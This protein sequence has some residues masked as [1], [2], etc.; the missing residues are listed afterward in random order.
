MKKSWALW[1]VWNSVWSYVLFWSLN[2][3]KV[4]LEK[5]SAFTHWVALYFPEFLICFSTLCS[6]AA[7]PPP[8]PPPCTAAQK[9]AG[10]SV[11]EVLMMAEVLVVTA[12]KNKSCML[13]WGCQRELAYLVILVHSGCCKA[14]ALAGPE[15]HA[16]WSSG[17]KACLRCQAQLEVQGEEDPQGSKQLRDNQGLARALCRGPLLWGLCKPWDHPSGVHPFVPWL[18][19]RLWLV[20]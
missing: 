3:I 2:Q 15:A 13:Q 17:S 5:A 12:G 10:R 14:N 19:W 8:P 16:G 20:A 1:Q 18:W 4:L 7:F 9:L 11:W 6:C